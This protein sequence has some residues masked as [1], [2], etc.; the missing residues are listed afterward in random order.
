MK[1]QYIAP[2]TQSTEINIAELICGSGDLR[3]GLGSA[4]KGDNALSRG[5]KD[6]D[7]DDL[8]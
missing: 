3:Y 8:W 5:R 4:E 6:N 1:K 2:C 7:D